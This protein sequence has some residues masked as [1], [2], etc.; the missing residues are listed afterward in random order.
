M[1]SKITFLKSYSALGF[2][3]S[4]VGSFKQLFSIT[5]VTVVAVDDDV[6][7]VVAVSSSNDRHES[8]RTEG[9]IV[10]SLSNDISNRNSNSNGNST[11]R[12]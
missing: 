10:N 6:V 11:S 3:S 5:A 4:F 12:L 2:F 1:S 9:V 7:V 8:T